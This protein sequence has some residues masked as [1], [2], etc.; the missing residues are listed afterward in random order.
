MLWGKAPSH[1]LE[2]R[3]QYDRRECRKTS[4]ALPNTQQKWFALWY[5]WAHGGNWSEGK[6]IVSVDVKKK[7]KMSLPRGLRSL[8]LSNVWMIMIKTGCLGPWAI[9]SPNWSSYR[10]CVT[11]LWLEMTAV[12][13]Y[14]KGSE[15]SSCRQGCV[16]TVP[17]SKFFPDIV[18]LLLC[19]WGPKL[20]DDI[21]HFCFT[22]LYGLHCYLFQENSTL[23]RRSVAPV[24]SQ[25][26]H[27]T[28][29]RL[30]GVWFSELAFVGA[31]S[32][33]WIQRESPWTSLG[34]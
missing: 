9:S 6:S 13:G 18:L 3:I 28:P 24:N 15:R 12:K 1:R 4:W 32:I 19:E 26:E 30:L 31:K 7:I 23:S 2:P 17:I 10:N 27:S 34:N 11:Y 16:K 20:F 8:F 29:G 25:T 5:S 14:V 21:N 22:F 33:C